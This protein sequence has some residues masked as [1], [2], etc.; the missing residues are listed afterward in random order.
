VHARRGVRAEAPGEEQCFHRIHPAPGDAPYELD[1]AE[2]DELVVLLNI[3]CDGLPFAERMAVRSG[4]HA[5]VVTFEEW[6]TELYEFSLHVS[7]RGV[8]TWTFELARQGRPT[9]LETMEMA[10]GLQRL[11][12]PRVDIVFPPP[13]F[14]F[15]RGMRTNAAPSLLIW[16]GIAH[17]VTN[18][19]PARVSICEPC[20]ATHRRCGLPQGSDHS[21][22]F[23]LP[24]MPKNCSGWGSVPFNIISC[25]NGCCTWAAARN[26]TGTTRW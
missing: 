2:Y 14:V 21:G 15:H 22:K 25:T 8:M 5:S 4:G 19:Q 11:F 16:R 12:S 1:E 10:L 13:S 6:Q 17:Q 9:E 20:A 23:N 18:T 26:G 24:R 7:Q 3:N